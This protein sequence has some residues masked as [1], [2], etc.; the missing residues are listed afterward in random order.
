M[1]AVAFSL[2]SEAHLMVIRVWVPLQPRLS[3]LAHEP[4]RQ[5]L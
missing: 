4:R 2:L 5:S 3:S 1:N